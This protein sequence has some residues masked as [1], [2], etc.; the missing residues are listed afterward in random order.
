VGS[1]PSCT[2]LTEAIEEGALAEAVEA[3]G[4]SS[5]SRKV[6]KRPPSREQN[7]LP[8][9]AIA[10]EQGRPLKSQFLAQCRTEFRTP[11]TRSWATPT[12]CEQRHRPG[13]DRSGKEAFAHRLE[14]AAPAALIND[15]LD[16][17]RTRRAECR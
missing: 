10:L 8:P 16:S 11:L 3:G 15:I 6:R 1:R 7:E 2:T 9:P 12:C 14:R 5:S 17:T 13:D 4:R